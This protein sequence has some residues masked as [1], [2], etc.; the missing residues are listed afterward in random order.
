[1][2][3]VPSS[4]CLYLL[5]VYLPSRV[6]GYHPAPALGSPEEKRH[7]LEKL[8]SFENLTSASSP[9][10]LRPPSH[11]AMEHWAK[12][13]SH[14]HDQRATADREKRLKK[15][16][17]DSK[18]GRKGK[19]SQHHD[20]HYHQHQH[21][22]K[23]HDKS[24]HKPSM[25]GVHISLKSLGVRSPAKIALLAESVVHHRALSVANSI[26][27]STVGNVIAGNATNG[28]MATSGSGFTVT[29]GDCTITSPADGAEG[30]CVQSPNYPSRY[31][32]SRRRFWAA[33]RVSGRNPDH[34]SGCTPECVI[35]VTDPRP[36]E[37]EDF[38]VETNYDALY[39]NDL[40]FTGRGVQ[41]G[42]QSVV[43]TGKM[44]WYADYSVSYKGFSICKLGK[45]PVEHEGVS[46]LAAP[47]VGAVQSLAD[48]IS[49]S[50]TVN[51]EEI[52]VKVLKDGFSV[53]GCFDDSML[54][55]GD[56]FGNG[57]FKYGSSASSTNISIAKYDE[58]VHDDDQQ[59]M[60]PEVCF[61]FCR[62]I[63]GMVYFGISNGDDCYCE[64]YYKNQA[65]DASSCHIPC[66]GD[67]TRMCGGKKKSTIWEMHLCQDTADD[68]KAG[69]IQGIEALVFFHEGAALAVDL[70]A[71]MTAAGVAL[72]EV[73]GL[74]GSPATR[75][76]GTAATQ[77]GGVLAK[78]W[79][80]GKAAY[81]ALF[82]ATTEAKGLKDADFTKASDATKA[83]HA[84][85]DISTH[86]GKVERAADD[87]YDLI[88]ATYPAL[89][90]E[91]LGDSFTDRNS[92]VKAVKNGSEAVDFRLA[93]YA[94][95]DL[96]EPEAS[97]CSGQAL[98]MPMVALGVNGCA[99]VCQEIVYPEMC[100]AFA[101]YEVSGSDDLCFLFSDV[102]DVETFEPPAAA[103]LAQSLRKKAVKAAS[104]VCKI[105]MSQ[106]A[107]GFKPKGNIKRNK[108]WFGADGGFE[109][110]EGTEFYDIPSSVEIQGTKVI[111]KME[112][113]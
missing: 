45:W 40:M 91:D 66:A 20:G 4:L 105:K 33:C 100:V 3:C 93:P 22:E 73:A 103:A 39:V 28:N 102:T 34:L 70:G 85:K 82:E 15:N 57:K 32:N 19:K 14:I 92:L 41:Y 101:H 98:G 60:T 89:D 99:I 6:L 69:T 18:K 67:T 74:S 56:K 43:P 17:R 1:M 112:P 25:C 107:T 55:Y 58:L 86:K 76:L 27:N 87:I 80:D 48:D 8:E 72:E 21:T 104:A 42:P 29:E 61:E 78:S 62:T 83:E 2:T 75:S 26:G 94:F 52:Y 63:K 88:I 7:G 50:G 51:G 46:S 84:I 31:S 95:G 38:Y 49:G 54:E 59:A 97:S 81:D 36:L 90:Y 47:G 11:D 64:P 79:L 108:R 71:K 113:L 23:H 109:P 37:V 106:I 5:L 110:R 65:G 16:Q 111:E 24:H 35:E 68:L 53:V 44:K 12:I 10:H 96:S 77:A 9:P 13:E 30:S